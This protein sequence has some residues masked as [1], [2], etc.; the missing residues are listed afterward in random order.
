MQPASNSAAM[1]ES[2][3]LKK[4]PKRKQFQNF[5]EVETPSCSQCKQ[6]PTQKALDSLEAGNN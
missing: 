2:L 6:R 4:T 3:G 5:L 1:P